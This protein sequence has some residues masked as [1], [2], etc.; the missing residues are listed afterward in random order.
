MTSYT[1]HIRSTAYRYDEQQIFRQWRLFSRVPWNMYVIRRPNKR[2]TLLTWGAL[3]AVQQPCGKDNVPG[4]EAL[5]VGDAPDAIA[6]ADCV[7]ALTLEGGGT[8]TPAEPPREQGAPSRRTGCSLAEAGDVATVGDRDGLR[9]MSN[10][11]SLR[12]AF[13]SSL[14]EW[15]EL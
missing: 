15:V 3:P 9:P 4:A 6:S 13:A 7:A 14:N 11:L 1:T 12:L 8:P 2:S 10:C 5:A